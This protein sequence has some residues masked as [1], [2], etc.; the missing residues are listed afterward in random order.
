MSHSSALDDGRG[1]VYPLP[2]LVAVIA[3]TV[4]MTAYG[5]VSTS[6]RGPAD[7]S[8]AIPALKQVE[9]QATTG[10]V[11]DPAAVDPSA[12]E[13]DGYR[14]AVIIELAGERYAVGPSPPAHAHR[15]ETTVAIGQADAVRPGILRVEVWPWAA[16]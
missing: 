11:L 3:L 10:A 6:L 4:A 1:Q 5:G 16:P 8:P 14:V 15:A 7:P 2:A 12:A 13:L 9:A